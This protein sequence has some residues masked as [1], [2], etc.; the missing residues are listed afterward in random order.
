MNKIE[1][2]NFIDAKNRTMKTAKKIKLLQYGDVTKLARLF[3]CSDTMVRA[4]LTNRSNT[5]LA[6]R[7]RE[8]VRKNNTEFPYVEY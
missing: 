2:N 4:A 6:E 1:E 7:I 5:E 8:Y 3:E